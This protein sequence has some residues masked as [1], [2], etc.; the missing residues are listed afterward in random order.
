MRTQAY[1]PLFLYAAGLRICPYHDD[2]AAPKRQKP[3]DTNRHHTKPR[4][5]N[6][7]VKT[8]EEWKQQL[9][10]EQYHILRKAGTEM[11]YTGKYWNKKDDGTYVCAGCGQEL[12]TSTTKFDSGCGWPSFYDAIDSGK[13]RSAKITRTAC[14]ARKWCAAAA[15][16]ISAM[17]S[18]MAPTPPACATASTPKACTSRSENSVDIAVFYTRD[19]QSPLGAN[20]MN[21]FAM[22]LRLSVLRTR[23]LLNRACAKHTWR[24]APVA[25]KFIPL[26]QSSILRLDTSL[27]RRF[28]SL[29]EN[30]TAYQTLARRRRTVAGHWTAAWRFAESDP[31]RVSA[32]SANVRLCTSCGLPRTAPS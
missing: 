22:S 24:A 25:K 31:R 18:R 11:P 19:K 14:A 4:P 7:V 27:R 3:H 15:A 8:E 28:R 6:K 13:V 10:P 32:G 16:G 12:F 21:S 1:G 23:M 20:G 5:A 17:S 9:T 30:V 26:C 2:P 29:C